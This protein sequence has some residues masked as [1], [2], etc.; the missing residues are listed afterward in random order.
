MEQDV[1]DYSVEVLVVGSGS[2]GF[3][4][5]IKAANAGS[6]T[7]LIE[8]TELVGGC[9]S[10]SGGGLWIPGSSVIQEAGVKDS[11][12][13]ARIY[14]DE[15][16]GDVGPAS[17]PQRREAFLTEGP[18]MV[19]FLRS[20][21]M[22]FAYVKGYPD[23]YPNKEGGLAVGR[24]IEGE[25]FNINEL[26]KEWRNKFRGLLPMAMRTEDAHVISKTFSKQGLGRLMTIML[27]R[28]AGGALAG[29]KN[30]G[31]GVA[32]IG[33]LL[34][35]ALRQGVDIWLES[36]LTKLIVKD[37]RV[38][39]ALVQKEGKALR[40]KASKGVILAAGGFA[41]NLEMREKYHPKPISTEWTSANPGDLGDGIIAGMDVGAATAL[42]DDAWWGPT[43]INPNGSAQFMI[44]ERSN[45][46]SII[47]D[48]A[49][50]RFMNES[51]SY[52][53][54][55][56][57]MY[58]HNEKVPCIPAYMI[59]DSNHRKRYMLGMMMPKSNSKA[60]FS[61]GFLTQANTLEELAEKVHI[62]AAALKSTVER[63]NGFCVTGIDEDFGRG[64]NAYD[65]FYS[66]AA[67]AKPNPN[68]GPIAVPPFY[69]LKVW[70]GDLSTKGGLLTD[71]FARVLDL[72]GAV[73][74]GLY[75]TGNNSAAVMGRTYPGAGST[76]GQAMTFGY[77]AAK[78][79][80]GA[81]ALS[82]AVD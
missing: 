12:E 57:W 54:C 63:F 14:M 51:A 73:I 38:T 21:G 32:L 4:A 71:E 18:A 75:A 74:E 34:Q 50:S 59:I 24:C 23:Y 52:V 42:M 20:I 66:D 10:M 48:M 61:S 69:A 47:V 81:Y 44:W 79:A 17:S 46:F 13:Q 15:I 8:S 80:T 62:D 22:V 78:H 67:D 29:K 11:A 76:I 43:L 49:G 64:D 1:F 82:G 77:V 53:D 56:H 65:R 60:A 35:V 37:G 6:K 9:S 36:P 31:L 68:L 25:I 3:A 70:P 40:I 39:G 58:E 72:S 2:G 33:R 7:L 55:G 5:A 16:I 41:Q 26:P 45:P 27:K 30:R 19:D 28:G